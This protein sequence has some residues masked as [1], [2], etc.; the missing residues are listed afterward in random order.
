M[1]SMK[2]KKKKKRR[3]KNKNLGDFAFENL[4]ERRKMNGWMGFQNQIGNC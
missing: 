2:K 4:E 1:G 3:N